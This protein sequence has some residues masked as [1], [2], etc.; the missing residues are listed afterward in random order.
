MQGPETAPAP[1]FPRLYEN[2]VFRLAINF[3]DRYPMEPPGGY[4]ST[5]CTHLP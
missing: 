1:G 2:E 3:T 4:K 5:C